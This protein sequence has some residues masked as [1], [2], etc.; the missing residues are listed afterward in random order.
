MFWS[1]VLTSWNT[2]FSWPPS[3]D[4]YLFFFILLCLLLSLPYRFSLSAHPLN[5][6]VFRLL[7][8]LHFTHLPWVILFTPMLVT[9]KYISLFLMMFLNLSTVQWNSKVKLF[10]IQLIFSPYPYPNKTSPTLVFLPSLNDTTGHR[11]AEV[12]KNLLVFLTVS[13]S[14]L[15]FLGSTTKLTG[16]PKYFQFSPP[17]CYYPSLGLFHRALG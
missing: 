14:L 13:L 9:L 11:V 1:L 3:P 7:A 17:H 6:S 2:P 8:H 12:K 10:K 4:T 16:P 5:I 15:L